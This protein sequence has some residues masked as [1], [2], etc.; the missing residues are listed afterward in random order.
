MSVYLYTIASLFI[1]VRCWE[2]EI[3]KTNIQFDETINTID[4]NWIVCNFLNYIH[5][6][7]FYCCLSIAAAYYQEK[8]FQ[9]SNILDCFNA[10]D[11]VAQKKWRF[12]TKQYFCLHK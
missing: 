1:N 3:R 8:W 2:Q 4:C 5:F 10:D 11:G 9:V 12:N 7:M 6:G